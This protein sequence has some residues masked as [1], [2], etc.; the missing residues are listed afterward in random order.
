MLAVIVNFYQE[1]YLTLLIPTNQTK[2]SLVSTIVMRGSISIKFDIHAYFRHISGRT[3]C[4]I[5]QK[6]SMIRL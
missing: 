4:K 2:H 3:M 1:M 5:N 6:T